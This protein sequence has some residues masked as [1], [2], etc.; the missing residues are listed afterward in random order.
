M[1]A[2]C[3]AN[4]F[5]VSGIVL[6]SFSSFSAGKAD[7]LDPFDLS[8]FT[9]EI[10]SHQPSAY[11]E[12]SNLLSEIPSDVKQAIVP[13]RFLLGE[14]ANSYQFAGLSFQCDQFFG[15]ESD[16]SLSGQRCRPFEPTLDHQALGLL[17]APVLAPLVLF[18]LL[19]RHC[20]HP[21]SATRL[22]S[23]KSAYPSRQ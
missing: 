1:M 15:S 9:Q 23:K 8:N 12:L 22:P 17:R 10:T 20:F 4:T 13:V 2:K 18:L 14:T 16:R 6:I 21:C 11:Q 19:C 7:S 5:L 3:F